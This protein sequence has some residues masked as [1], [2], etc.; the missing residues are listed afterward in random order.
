[1]LVARASI[2]RTQR[3]ERW[4]ELLAAEIDL[5]AAPKAGIFA[6]GK[7]VAKHLSRR[8]FSRPFTSVIHYSGLAASARAAGIAAHQSEFEQFRTSVCLEDVL[9]TAEEV[10]NESVPPGFR[11]EA[12]TRLQAAQ[13]SESRKQLA[14]NYKLAFERH[15]HADARDGP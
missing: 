6:V 8:G 11:T 7:D 10:L 3:Y 9:A 5:V 1:M 4:Y 2:D 14:F 15:K 13:L 12:L